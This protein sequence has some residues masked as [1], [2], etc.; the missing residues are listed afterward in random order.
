MEGVEVTSDWA[1]P[2]ERGLKV[3]TPGKAGIGFGEPVGFGLFTRLA[4]VG[5]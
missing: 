4:K 1:K 5:S 3:G 2:G